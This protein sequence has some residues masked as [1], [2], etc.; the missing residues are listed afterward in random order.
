MSGDIGKNLNTLV[1]KKTTDQGFTE[2]DFQ[3]EALTEEASF[4]LKALR[5]PTGIVNPSP[6]VFDQVS[7]TP[8]NLLLVDENGSILVPNQH[9]ILSGTEVQLINGVTIAASGIVYGKLRNVRQK[10][11]LNLGEGSQISPRNSLGVGQILFNLGEPF[12]IP[13]GNE[14][15]PI[16][17]MRN[18]YQIYLNDDYTWYDPNGTGYSQLIL[19]SRAGE[20]LPGGV[21]EEIQVFLNGLKVE[22]NPLN[23]KRD[24]ETI[25][26][27]L[28]R[29]FQF[30]QT[31][32][33][34]D[35]SVFRLGAPAFTDFKAFGD[36]MLGLLDIAVPIQ[37]P[38]QAFTP[39]FRGSVSDP[40]KGAIDYEQFEWRQNGP[41]LEFH[42]SYRHT[43]AGTAGSGIYLLE[44]PNDSIAD[45]V[46]HYASASGGDSGIVGPCQF[47][48]GEFLGHAKLYDSRHFSFIGAT[49]AIAA[50]QWSSTLQAFS[51]I[52]LR[53]TVTGKVPIVGFKATKT[54]RE[55]LQEASVLP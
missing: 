20:L 9:Y 38:W 30:I 5:T 54:I 31:N 6:A 49:N 4:N 7:L 26:G 25:N 19:L 34:I 21:Q 32:F 33:S 28:D 24:I 8:V 35:P 43:T 36:I 45:T 44:V 10:P 27:Q 3:H 51:N 13:T 1:S 23:Q 52:N 48:A 12:K 2:V 53:M 17:V 50:G 16:M 15:D 11:M 39:V 37:T 41:D 55:I 46:K 29:V 14:P 22:K 47:G 42:G 18:R 40:T